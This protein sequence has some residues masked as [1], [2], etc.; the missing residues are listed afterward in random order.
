MIDQNEKLPLST[1][2]EDSLEFDVG[3]ILED[4]SHQGRKLGEAAEALHHL[5]SGRPRVRP[6]SAPPQPPTLG[7]HIGAYTDLLQTREPVQ[8]GREDLITAAEVKISQCQGR[9]VKP[10]MVLLQSAVLL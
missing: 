8:P 2:S 1:L 10:L 9:A 5:V 3:D 6:V 4:E 7:G